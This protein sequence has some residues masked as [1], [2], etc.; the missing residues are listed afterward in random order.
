MLDKKTIEAL[1]KALG[2]TAEDI[3]AKITSDQEESLEI[4]EGSFFTEEQLTKRDNVKYSEGKVAGSEMLVKDLKKKYGYEIEGKDVDTFFEHHD[5]QLKG[6]YSKDSSQKLLDLEKDMKKMKETYES[7]LQAER[8][9][10]GELKGKLNQQSITNKLLNI[11]PKDTTIKREAVITLFNSEYNTET[12]DGQT[13]VVRNGERIK[14]PKTAEPI[15][16]ETVFNDFVVSEGYVKA[17]SGRGGK[18]EFGKSSL[19]TAKDPMEFTSKWQSKNPDKHTTS[20]EYKKDYQEWMKSH[21][22]PA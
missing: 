5:E 8:S 15:P 7:E 18:D 6:K 12:E 11:M 17:P 14:D 16:L 10:V 21:Q 2:K 1:A 9:R 4:P 22:Q 19:V 3:T 20:P 13:F